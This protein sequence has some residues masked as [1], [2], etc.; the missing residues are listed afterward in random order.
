[1]KRFSDLVKTGGYATEVSYPRAMSKGKKHSGQT[2]EQAHPKMSH[3]TWEKGKE[4][5]NVDY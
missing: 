3:K 2:C 5:T 4:A 1:M